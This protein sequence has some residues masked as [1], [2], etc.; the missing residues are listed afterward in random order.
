[1]WGAMR[2]TNKV[3]DIC[4]RCRRGGPKELVKGGER[5]NLTAWLIFSALTCGCGLPLAFLFYSPTSMMALC[6]HCDHVFDTD[7]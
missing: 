1:M 4:P 7:R 6:P 3:M 2:S 5:F